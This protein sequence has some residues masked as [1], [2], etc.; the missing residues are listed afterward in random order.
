VQHVGNP[1]GTTS[2]KQSEVWRRLD[3]EGGGIQ[4]SHMKVSALEGNLMSGE[5]D[6]PMRSSPRSEVAAHMS[7]VGSPFINKLG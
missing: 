1:F 4:L 2:P 5:Y 6:A 7:G 3:S